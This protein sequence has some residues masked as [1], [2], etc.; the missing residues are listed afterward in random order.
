M[1]GLR[2]F[3]GHSMRT[4]IARHVMRSIED[5]SRG[6][7]AL[8]RVYF[9]FGADD[10][11]I[12]TETQ[13]LP[14]ATPGA[15]YRITAEETWYGVAKRA[16]GPDNLKKNLL[17]L[18]ASTWNDHISR[19]TK[20]WE[21]YG[22]KGLQSTPDY[23]SYQYP[24][25]KV[26]SGTA[27]PV[28]WIPPLTGQE[29]EEMGFNPKPEPEPVM[30][31][32]TPIKTPTPTPKPIVTQGPPGPMGPIGPPGIPGP[33]GPPG[34]GAGASIPGPPGPM[35][36]VGP[37]GI[38]GPAGPIGP[39]GPSGKGAG[40]SIPGP[41]GPMG[42]IGPPGIPGPPGPQGIPG[43]AAKTTSGADK[44]LWAIPL[45]ISLLAKA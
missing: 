11:Y 3:P 24:R 43:I 29:P 32:P 38:P 35:G 41:P 13:I 27:Y 33:P 7:E 12:P 28:A 6:R 23:D 14:K 10:R 15:W 2:V 42:P 17:M 39:P 20:G 9:A 4:P 18:N 26:M 19:K 31:V 30:T 22:V 25:A 5:I 34:K 8:P 44:G 40:A 36:P 37:P 45:A 21:S 1:I 16:Y